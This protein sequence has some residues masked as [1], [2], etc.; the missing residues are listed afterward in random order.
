MKPIKLLKSLKEPFANVK[1]HL[2]KTNKKEE[3]FAD[4]KYT[5]LREGCLHSPVG[6]Y[7]GTR[8]HVLNVLLNAF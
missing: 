6:R 2:L 3:A 4:Y 1:F 5:T 8:T 7:H